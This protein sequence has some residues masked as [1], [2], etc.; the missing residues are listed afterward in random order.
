[1]GSS[2]FF[3]FRDASVSSRSVKAATLHVLVPCCCGV[4]VCRLLICSASF[5]LF[6]ER[7]ACGV[8]F[9]RQASVR[10]VFGHQYWML[11]D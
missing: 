2:V 9:D 3:C 11:T 7:V 8:V 4:C 1:M 6:E 10:C 5:P